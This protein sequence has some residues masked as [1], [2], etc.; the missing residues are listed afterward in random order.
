MEMM[1]KMASK[2]LV[3]RLR[4][5][6]EVEYVAFPGAPRTL[7]HSFLSSQWSVETKGGRVLLGAIK[8]DSFFA[9]AECS[10][11]GSFINSWNNIY[12]SPAEC[13]LPP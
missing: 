6:W 12:L 4:P 1:V 3:I 5:K 8:F 9:L 13:G 11:L 7:G 2:T 10:L